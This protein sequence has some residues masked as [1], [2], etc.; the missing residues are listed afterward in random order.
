MAIRKRH[1]P[2]RTATNTT[3]QGLA[4]YSLGVA[5]AASTIIAEYEEAAEV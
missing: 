2:R 1:L 4:S 3:R 5:E